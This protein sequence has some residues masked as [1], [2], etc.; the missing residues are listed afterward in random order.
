MEI[1]IN[2][3]TDGSRLLDPDY[4]S[5]KFLRNVGKLLPHYRASYSAGSIRQSY[6]CNILKFNSKRIA[7]ILNELIAVLASS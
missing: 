4:G 1:K 3:Q 6:R 7:Q 2:K 5:N